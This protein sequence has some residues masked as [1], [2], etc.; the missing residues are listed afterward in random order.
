MSFLFWL[1]SIRNPFLDQVMKLFTLLGSELLF[2]VLALMIFWCVDKREGYYLLFVGFFGTILNQFLKLLCRI[3]RPWV[4][5]DLTVVEGAK[6]DAGGFSF[7]S[8]HT[9]NITGTL[10]S[11][12]RWHRQ[13]WLRV[14]C[15]VLILMTSFSR[16][17]LGVHTPWDVGVS[18]VIGTVLIFVFYPIVR[19]TA[20]HPK[21]MYLLLGIMTVL[22][23]AFTLYA[24]LCSF[25]GVAAADWFNIEEG[26]KNSFS[27]L[28][29]LLGFCVAYPLE[30]K[31][32]HFDEKAVWWVQAI[33][34]LGGLAGLLLIKEG[35]KALFGLINFTWLG[36]NAIRYFVV[37]L[38]AA[39][40]WPMTFSRLG[41]LSQKK[42]TEGGPHGTC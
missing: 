18:L 8:G 29:A 7:P 35:L 11:V 42:S 38:F 4:R 1:E 21:R 37:V 5:S 39:L 17:Y 41:R 16:M 25:E 27:L 3:P 30:R 10:G 9:Q 22:S 24:N 32:V 40:V 20:D 14:L 34:L 36:S 12:A 6:E 13:T 2:I 31:Y 19:S 15:V 23:L 33:K 26:R 28:G